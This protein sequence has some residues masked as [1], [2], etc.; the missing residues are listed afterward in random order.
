MRVTTA[1]EHERNDAAQSKPKSPLKNRPDRDRRGRQ[2]E[3]LA[4]ILSV[5]R[6]IQG[7]SRWTAEAIAQEVGCGVRTVYRD[8]PTNWRRPQ[9]RRSGKSWPT[10][11]GWWRLWT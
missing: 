5:L 4:R 3:R 11:R 7:R 1:K 6:L 8:L 2:A 9:A 10:P